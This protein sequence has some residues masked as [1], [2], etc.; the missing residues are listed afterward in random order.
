MTSHL[1][2]AAYAALAATVIFLCLAVAALYRM[3]AASESPIT[4]RRIGW[5]LEIL[6]PG[7][8]APKWVRDLV[9][10]DGVMLLVVVG[11]D[12][13]SE[14]AAASVVVAA[15]SVAVAWKIFAANRR[16]TTQILAPAL[17]GPVDVLDGEHLASLRVV[18]LPV[19]IAVS[20]G[21]VVDAV[22]GVM[23]P[24]E[25]V[26]LI[27]RINPIMQARDRSLSVLPTNTRR[28]L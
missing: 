11:P 19:V 12:E 4:R 20:R 14:A 7:D 15:N 10:D 22:A 23:G 3:L 21:H 9:D 18:E 13:A 1:W 2:V 24:S 6:R 5:P 17:L 8:P 16:T 26:R 25:V 27:E 28:T